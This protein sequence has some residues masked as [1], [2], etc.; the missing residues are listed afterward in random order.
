MRDDKTE[1]NQSQVTLVKSSQ[2][3]EIKSTPR[4][5]NGEKKAK[6]TLCLV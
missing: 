6:Q 3:C 2:K 4:W 1:Y 5:P